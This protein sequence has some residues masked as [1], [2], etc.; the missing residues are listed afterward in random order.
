VGD[1]FTLTWKSVHLILLS[2]LAQLIINRDS[3]RS[4]L[5]DE[6]PELGTLFSVFSEAALQTSIT[7]WRTTTRIWEELFRNDKIKNASAHTMA[8][9]ILAFS[10]CC[11]A[12][13]VSP[14]GPA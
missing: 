4:P 9:M 7:R 14:R 3:G 5:M 8:R 2:S 10:E 6:Q 13:E 11:L 12:R 1:P